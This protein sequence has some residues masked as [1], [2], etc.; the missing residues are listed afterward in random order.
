MPSLLV[1]SPRA[2]TQPAPGAAYNTSVTLTDV[3]AAPQFIL[4]GNTITTVGQGFKLYA[5]GVQSNVATAPTLILGFYKATSGTS[6][7]GGAAI[8]AIAATTCTVGSNL[9]WSLY[10]EGQFTAT[11]SS[12]TF[13]GYGYCD[14]GTS[15]TATTHIP[16]PN[17][18]PQTA[19]SWDTTKNSIITV[20][21]QWGTSSA[22]NTLTCNVFTIELTS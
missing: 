21:A 4:Q 19:V 18:T 12:G 6:G 11:G 2:Y 13:F 3:S 16:I 15:A 7:V 14:F 10:L 22:S 17:A 8:G 9:I 1:P 5:A 20:G